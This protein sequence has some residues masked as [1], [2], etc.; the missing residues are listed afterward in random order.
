[1][2]VARISSRTLTNVFDERRVQFKKDNYAGIKAG[3][4]TA[5]LFISD[6]AVPIGVSYTSRR[7][8]S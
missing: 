5:R 8:C 1:M 6:Y 3:I 7:D 2:R 4:R